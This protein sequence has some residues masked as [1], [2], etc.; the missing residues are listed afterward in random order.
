MSKRL[1]SLLLALVLLL[2]LAPAASA[3]GAIAT[4]EELLAFLARQKEAQAEEFAFTC[5][6]ALFTRLMAEDAALLNVLQIKAGIGEA[7]V[8]YSEQSCLIRCPQVAYSDA[9]WA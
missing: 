7:R 1:L 2:A 9:P 8:Q 4:E 6:P 3:E 5:E